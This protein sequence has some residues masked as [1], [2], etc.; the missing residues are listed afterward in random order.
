[1]NIAETVDIVEPISKFSDSLKG[2]EGVGEIFNTGIE[3]WTPSPS[4]D[5]RYDLVWSQWCLG[6]LTD[7]QL[8]VYLE[9]CG[10]MLKEGGLVV[11]KE[12]LSTGE[13]DIFDKVDSSVTRYLYHVR[14]IWTRI[15]DSRQDGQK[16]SGDL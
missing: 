6:Y 13:D 5:S 9:K 2:K 10:K 7:A 3:D 14:E 11:V 4:D 16:V 8:V 1:M 12:N 15:T